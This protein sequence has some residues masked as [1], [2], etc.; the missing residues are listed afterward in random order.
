MFN[1]VMMIFFSKS[2]KLIIKNIKVFLHS[3]L[4]IV[5]LKSNK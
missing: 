4:V 1:N 2:L 3:L 5:K